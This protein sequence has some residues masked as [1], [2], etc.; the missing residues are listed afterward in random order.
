MRTIYHKFLEKQRQMDLVRIDGITKELEINKVWL[1]SMLGDRGPERGDYEG[2]G[3][4][5]VFVHRKAAPRE[6]EHG[7]HD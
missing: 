2:I 7:G 1:R 4:G 6:A 3:A 5:I